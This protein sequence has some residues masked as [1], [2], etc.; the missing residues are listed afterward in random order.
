[1]SEKKLGP[2]DRCG[3]ARPGKTFRGKEVTLHYSAG[4]AVLMRKVG[5]G[6]DEFTRPVTGV[7]SA[8]PPVADTPKPKHKRRG[9]Y[10]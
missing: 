8:Y 3:G 2:S 7:Q 9:K 1:M 5:Q 10:A 4:D 6:A